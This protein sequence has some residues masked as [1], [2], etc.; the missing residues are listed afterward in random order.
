MI[1]GIDA[2]TTC[3][4]ISVFDNDGNLIKYGII[5]PE[6]S[7]DWRERI[8]IIGFKISDIIEHYDITNIIMENVPKEQK[9]IATMQKLSVLQ[10]YINCVA[11]QHQ[12]AMTFYD[13]S[14]WRSKLKM[15]DGTRQGTKRKEMKA[16][17]VNM[18]NELFNLDLKASQDDIAEAVLIGHSYFV[19]TQFGT[20]R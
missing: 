4:G 6:K 14:Q 9:N 5:K 16:K 19:K 12:C 20:I 11:D 3:S 1:L 18:A 7:E 10:G 17:A 2:S 8:R 15:F 13:P